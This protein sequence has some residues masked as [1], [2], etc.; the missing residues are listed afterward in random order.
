MDTN[1]HLH[2]LLEGQGYGITN[3]SGEYVVAMNVRDLAKACGLKK[4]SFPED[5]EKIDLLFGAKKQ[6][7]PDL[8]LFLKQNPPNRAK[9]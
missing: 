4:I 1:Y 6:M 8:R 2:V 5:D 7:L 3:S 9:S